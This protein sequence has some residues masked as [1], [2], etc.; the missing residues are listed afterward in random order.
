MLGGKLLMAFLLGLNSV[1]FVGAI[2]S[3]GYRMFKFIKKLLRRMRRR[4][5]EYEDEDGWD[6]ENYECDVEMEI[7]SRGISYR[8]RARKYF[9]RFAIFNIA[10]AVVAYGW[11]NFL[12]MV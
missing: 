8:K 4:D 5:Y 7:G 6:S 12:A 1:L 9:F 3:A 10:L 11:Y 2:I